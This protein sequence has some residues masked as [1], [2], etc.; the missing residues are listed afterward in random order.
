[1][2]PKILDATIRIEGDEVILEGDAMLPPE[3]EIKTIRIVTNPKHPGIRTRPPTEPGSFAARIRAW[4][5]LKDFSQ[6]EASKA[7]GISYGTFKTWEHG[8]K[9]PRGLAK[10]VM[11]EIIARDEKA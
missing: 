9:E 7:I 1:M 6:L 2:K 4:R 8:S 11:E 5:L 10:R 3:I